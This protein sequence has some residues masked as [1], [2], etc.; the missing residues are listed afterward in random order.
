MGEDLFDN[1]VRDSPNVRL[2]DDV[3]VWERPILYQILYL[4]LKA[5][6]IVGLMARFLMKVTIFIEVQ[7]GGIGLGIGVGS[8]GFRNPLK[9]RFSYA[10]AR[11]FLGWK[12]LGKLSLWTFGRLEVV[13]THIY[14]VGCFRGGCSPPICLID[15]RL[16]LPFLQLSIIDGIFDPSSTIT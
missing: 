15:W 11:S 7:W 14:E 8:K 3:W 9:V 10:R 1:R 5:K 2:S 6:A 16:V 12:T 4:M 13:G